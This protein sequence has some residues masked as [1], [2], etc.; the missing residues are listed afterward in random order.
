M[1][2]ETPA[3]VELLVDDHA[4]QDVGVAA[5]AAVRLRDGAGR[6][7]VLDQELLPLEQRRPGLARGDA[8]AAF[9]GA[10]A[11]LAQERP[12]LAAEGLVL[13]S[14]AQVH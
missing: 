10:A 9:R 5:V 6:V 3:R 11:V 4:L 8:G 14:E 1:P 7:A 2:R 13:G 12:H